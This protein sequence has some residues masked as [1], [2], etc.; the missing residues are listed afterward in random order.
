[1]GGYGALYLGGQLGTPRTRVVVAESPALWHRYDQAAPGAF[2]DAA[3]FTRNSILGHLTR[4]DGI[5]L[6]VD[7]GDRDGFAP[8]TDDLRSALR[9]TPGRGHRGRRPQRRLLALP[10]PG[11]AALRGPAPALNPR[12]AGSVPVGGGVRCRYRPRRVTLQVSVGIPQSPWSLP[13]PS[14][15]SPTIRSSDLGAGDVDVDR[16]SRP[17]GPGSPAW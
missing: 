16:Q 9:P 8:I 1:M 11:P 12:Q 17:D 13:L 5:P 10:G 6:R 7:C 14:P 2:D 3:D 4:L 15:P